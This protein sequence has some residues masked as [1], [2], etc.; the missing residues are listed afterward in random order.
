[1]LPRELHVLG[2]DPGPTTGVAMIETAGTGLRAMTFQCNG[3]SAYWLVSQLLESTEGPADVLLAG[4]R[5][6]IGRGAGARSAAGTAT[7]EVIADLDGLGDWTWRTAAEVKPWATDKRLEAAGLLKQCHGMPHAGDACRH[8]LYM[9]VRDGGYPDPLS[10]R[11]RRAWQAAL[12]TGQDTG[13]LHARSM[14]IE[15]MLNG[16][17]DDG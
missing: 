5:F 13:G 11:A 17:G 12:E 2:V 7:R 14:T 15:E 1:M 8:A 6:I 16:P 10:A 3:S 9:A 4:E